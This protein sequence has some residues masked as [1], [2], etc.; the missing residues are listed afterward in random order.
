MS[1]GN[2]IAEAVF[3]AYRLKYISMCLLSKRAH[4]IP[5]NGPYGLIDYNGLILLTFA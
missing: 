3:N 1:N 2:R 4:T 5:K